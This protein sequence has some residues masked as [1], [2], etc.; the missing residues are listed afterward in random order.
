TQ[1]RVVIEIP[2]NAPQGAATR[3]FIDSGKAL[4]G[5]S[6]T[7]ETFAPCDQYSLEGDAFSLAIRGEAP[8]LYGVEDAIQNMRIIDA[9]FA[10]QRSGHWEVV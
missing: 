3:I 4:N 6:A 5:D 8:L 9:L 1:Q 7:V 2:F 10:S